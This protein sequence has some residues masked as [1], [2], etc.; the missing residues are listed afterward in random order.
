MNI[1]QAANKLLSALHVPQGSVNVLMAPNS[2]EAQLIVWVDGSVTI[3]G[4]R[5][6][7][8]FEGFKVK[9]EIKPQIT[10]SH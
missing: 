8:I 4:L 9:V 2:H 7:E 10:Y 6:P 5:I 1:Y 3:V